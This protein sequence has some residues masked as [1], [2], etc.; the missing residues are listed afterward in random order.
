GLETPQTI[1]ERTIGSIS[2]VALRHYDEIRVQ[3]VLHVDGRTITSNGLLDRHDRHAGI[4]RPALAFDRL[5][6]NAHAR[7]PG[8]DAFAHHAPHRHDPAMAG[9]AVHDDRKFHR[10]RDPTCDRHAFQHG[11]RA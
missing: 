2:R 9:I 8:A 7:D 3:L 5:I 1:L 11:Q 6:V 4:L 10:L